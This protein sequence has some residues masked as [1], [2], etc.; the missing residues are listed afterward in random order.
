MLDSMKHCVAMGGAATAWAAGVAAAPGTEGGGAA[1]PTTVGAGG[2]AMFR[3]LAATAGNS[4]PVPVG[5]RSE[6]L[7][8]CVTFLSQDVAF[9]YNSFI[10]AII[11]YQKI[12]AFQQNITPAFKF[13]FLD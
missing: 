6:L 11:L 4:K 5:K 8:F 1:P 12:S 13:L 9:Q 3:A 2:G 7:F 10:S